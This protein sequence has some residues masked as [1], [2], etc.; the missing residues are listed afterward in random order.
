MREL[1][2]IAC[3]GWL[4]ILSRYGI[5]RIALKYSMPIPFQTWGINILGSFLASI[6][7]VIGIEQGAIP[8]DL[9]TGL[10]V[11]FLGGFTTFSAYSLQTALLFD[12][13][14]VG[15]M[16]IY[17]VGSPVLGL[18]AALAGLWVARTLFS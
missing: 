16:L 9:R 5:D 3:L 14:A 2:S 13:K 8:S 6:V 15:P 7:F 17:F 10:M 4:G 12:K 1:I 11:G 18:S